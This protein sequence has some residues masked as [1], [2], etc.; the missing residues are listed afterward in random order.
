MQGSRFLPNRNPAPLMV[1][2]IIAWGLFSIL[3]GERLPRNAGFGW[4]GMFYRSITLHLWQ[5]NDE[6][7]MYHGMRCL[8][9][10]VIHYSLK[11]LGLPLD[12]P[13]IFQAFRL[14]NLFW[15]VVILLT[16]LSIADELRLHIQGKWLIFIGLCCSYAHL[17][18]YYYS[19]ILTDLW[20]LAF[21]T[22]A[23]R[24]FFK[25]Q[26]LAVVGW[27]F[28]GSFTWAIV[29][30]F[31]TLLILFPYRGSALRVTSLASSEGPSWP[32][33]ALAA[34]VAVLIAAFAAYLVRVERYYGSPPAQISHRALPVSVACLALFLYFA[35]QE[36]PYGGLLPR[37]R[38][39]ASF[40]LLRRVGLVAGLF[41]L[42]W[43]G[44]QLLQPYFSTR[45]LH[46]EGSFLLVRLICAFSVAKPLVSLLAQVVY[47]GPAVILLV[48]LWRPIV[49]QAQRY[50]AAT[51]L[52]LALGLFLSLCSEPRYP[53]VF[54]PLFL[55]LLASALREQS[56]GFG[57]LAALAGFGCFLSKAWMP[58]N[59]APWPP[60][61][62]FHYEDVFRF[63]M[64]AFFM[65]V[66]TWMTTSTYAIQAA[67]VVVVTLLIKYRIL[68]RLSISDPGRRQRG[69]MIPN[70]GVG[71]TTLQSDVCAS[72]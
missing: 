58:L 33:R 17:K 9:C 55:I 8:P 29:P 32:A 61:E 30:Y 16:L 65:N 6:V 18:Q 25:Q 49:R 48:L 7:T 57:R 56:L 19:P 37:W 2:L 40:D 50:G 59:W 26:R 64:Q 27:I 34:L 68:P 54:F 5:R 14:Y 11:T 45:Q 43:A 35:L 38:D 60:D 46:S 42:L 70:E 1:V 47:Y 4:D 3:C 10:V 39:L 72:A 69:E 24:S 66:G 23:L 62:P 52:G 28:L 15:S 63:P 31:G 44:G 51:V 36:L 67:V 53:L 41:V 71:Q 22:L 20:G 12:D 13:H 21:C